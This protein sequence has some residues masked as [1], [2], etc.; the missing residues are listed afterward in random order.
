MLYVLTRFGIETFLTMGKR[1][2][3]KTA[4]WIIMILNILELKQG[5]GKR[6]GISGQK[7]CVMRSQGGQASLRAICKDKADKQHFC[8]LAIQSTNVW[9]NPCFLTTLLVK[10]G[11]NFPPNLEIAICSLPR[12]IIRLPLS[13]N[14]LEL[15]V[16]SKQEKPPPSFFL[17]C[18]KASS[19]CIGS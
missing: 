17:A 9:I 4:L 3:K 18:F 12:V 2:F 8:P 5:R 15:I 14:V 1:A 16:I 13:S 11:S 10:K 19:I 6:E 7:M